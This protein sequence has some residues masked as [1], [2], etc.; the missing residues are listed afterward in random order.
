M[1]THFATGLVVLVLLGVGGVA[2]GAPRTR[3]DLSKLRLPQTVELQ[4]GVKI[5]REQFVKELDEL[6]EALESDGILIYKADHRPQTGKLYVHPN[7]AA[8]TAR[9]KAVFAQKLVVLR[10]HESKGFSGLLFKKGAVRP[11]TRAPVLDGVAAPPTTMA[12]FSI[13]ARAPASDDD[14]LQV[15]HEE[16]LGS[17]KRAAI[18]LAFGLKDTGDPSTIGCDASLDGG[19]YLFE[20]QRALVKVGAVGRVAD[21][22]ASGSLDIYLMG[23]AVDGFPKKGSTNQTL[24]KAIA[25]PSVGFSYGWGPLSI[26]ISGGISAELDLG[27]TSSQEPPQAPNAKTAASGF[28]GP[29]SGKCG[30]SLLPRVR[31]TGTLTASVNAALYRAKIKGTLVFMDVA[32]PNQTTVVARPPNLV[33]DF[34]ARIEASFLSGDVAL[35]IDTRIPQSFTDGFDWDKVYTKTLFDWD[36]LQENQKLASFH[37]KVTKL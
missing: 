25:P 8:E 34:D 14:P 3:A 35:Q 9:D 30:M 33:E 15:S 21:K 5:S 1:R 17:K 7:A 18:Y 27:V 36:G 31:A 10:A 22:R 32:L 26:G 13:P 6:Q 4:G 11:A 19:V 29:H 16:S 12:P 28:G 24:H 37:G 23:K 20:Q 2:H